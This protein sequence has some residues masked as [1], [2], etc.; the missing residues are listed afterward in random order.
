MND[1]LLF[2]AELSAVGLIGSVIVH[3][4]GLLGRKPPLGYFTFIFQFGAVAAA[5][6]AC[7]A[8]LILLSTNGEGFWKSALKSAPRWM[9]WTTCFFAGYAVLNLITFLNHFG[10]RE[11]M[12][13]DAVMALVFRGISGE[14]MAF[15]SASF[16]VFYSA[17]RARKRTPFQHS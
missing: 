12:L 10:H 7:L 13:P 2:F 11:G 1:F 4:L 16:L 14:W 3:S 5:F 8:L 9:K 17:I 15:Y 6:A